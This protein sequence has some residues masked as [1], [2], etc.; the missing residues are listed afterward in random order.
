MWEL[1]AI[2]A[3]SAFS[4]LRL[5][6]DLAL[7]NFALRHQL[8][9][10]QRQSKKARFEDRDRLVWIGLKRIWPR[11]TRALELVQPA[12]VVK[13][14]RVGFR[15]YWRRKSRVGGRPR[16]APDVRKLIRDMW[17]CNPTWGKP[18]IQAELAKLGVNVS[19]STVAKYR[20]KRRKPPSPTWRAF[21]ED[22]LQGIVALDFF[23]VPP[24]TFSILYV[25]VIMSHDRRRILHCNVT[26][27]PSA[28]WSGT[29]TS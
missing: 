27:A 24:A 18:R 25:L 4:A 15:Y 7:E 12:T 10:L 28:A 5:R 14:H 19:D 1:L 29:A 2:V 13:W 21:L 17:S 16:I 23:T 6:R 8:A 22:H 11:W 3:R 9:M 20:P 26:D